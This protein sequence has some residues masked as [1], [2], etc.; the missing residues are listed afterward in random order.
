[1]NKGKSSEYLQDSSGLFE[2]LL[3][4]FP[5]V[6]I[7]RHAFECPCLILAKRKELE[8]KEQV[9]TAAAQSRY[10]AEREHQECWSG[11]VWITTPT[12]V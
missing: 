9:L 11:T 10:A 8:Y 3:V 6:K 1:M 5:D 12:L 7:L 4:R 2:N